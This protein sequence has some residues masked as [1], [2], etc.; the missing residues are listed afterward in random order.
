MQKYYLITIVSSILI[1]I[2]LVIALIFYR[3]RH[4]K[5]DSKSEKVFSD[6]ILNL[7]LLNN[8]RQYFLLKEEILLLIEKGK[9]TRINYQ[10]DL[11]KIFRNSLSNTKKYQSKIIEEQNILNIYKQCCKSSLTD[12]E[13]L[14]YFF[15]ESGLKPNTIAE[16][17]CS[18][19][20]RIRSCRSRIN[21]KNTDC[22]ILS[23]PHLQ[24]E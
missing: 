3:N 4:K 16:V 19:P 12:I 21:K 6:K 1:N 11:N 15:S 8:S 24:D 20:E 14:V 23:I 9:F 10:S 17:L 5:P 2:S 18:T 22:G 13:S 7:L